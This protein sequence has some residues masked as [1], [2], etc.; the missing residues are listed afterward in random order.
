[1][2]FGTHL[3]LATS[4]FLY[5][6]ERN[7]K[8]IIEI[9]EK[10]LRKKVALIKTD[11]EEGR[12]QATP[13]GHPKGEPLSTG[14]TPGVAEFCNKKKGWP[15]APLQNSV[16][17]CGSPVKILRITHK[18]LPLNGLNHLEKFDY[19]RKCP[20]LPHPPLLSIQRLPNHGIHHK[21]RL[22]PSPPGIA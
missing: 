10:R 11:Y 19:F 21:L 8:T 5:F 20:K 7:S 1:L 6:E 12:L 13:A 15:K 14:L 9:D 4:L 16:I 22:H 2:K 3:Q 18:I 17:I